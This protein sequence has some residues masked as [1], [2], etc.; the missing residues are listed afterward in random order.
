M[1]KQI[2]A[3]FQC[4]TV[5]EWKQPDG[6]VGGQIVKFNASYAPN[7]DHPNYAFWKATPT[8][9]LEMTINNPAFDAFRPGKNY[10]LTFDEVKQA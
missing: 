7:P 4:N 10:L 8:A 1:S 3:L 9:N 6:S 2:Q 5:L